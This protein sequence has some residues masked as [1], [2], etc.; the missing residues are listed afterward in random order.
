M[1]GKKAILNAV[2]LFM[3]SWLVYEIYTAYTTRQQ[4]YEYSHPLTVVE[5]PTR[6]PKVLMLGNSLTSFHDL[7]HMTE[8]LVQQLSP[9][10]E[11][12]LVTS[13]DP[14]GYHLAD[15]LEDLDET[16]WP[17]DIRHALGD[18][19]TIAWRN[20]VLQDGSMVMYAPEDNFYRQRSH[21][22]LATLSRRILERGA[23]PIFYVTW[24]YSPTHTPDLT[25][26][27]FEEMTSRIAD[28]YREAGEQLAPHT[29]SYLPAGEAFLNM[30]KTHPERFPALY[31]DDRHTSVAGAYLVASLLAA[32]L[33]G[34]SVTPATWHPEGMSEEGAL[35]LRQLADSTLK[36]TSTTPAK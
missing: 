4:R 25:R 36:T 12:A 13:I 2:L 31:V 32:Q 8:R 9:E 3:L 6:T 28:G 11:R 18:D 23:H 10:W 15:H 26:Q 24:G 34:E 20:V 33:T 22:S 16:P 19:S 5:D 27:E 14:G 29:P 30:S 17:R 1:N 7:A 35:M 21:A